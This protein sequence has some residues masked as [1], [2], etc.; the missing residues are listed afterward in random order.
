[1]TFGGCVEDSDALAKAEA[2]VKEL[3]AELLEKDRLLEVVMCDH[4]RDIDD[5]RKSFELGKPTMHSSK[6]RMENSTLRASFDQARQS[7]DLS[8]TVG[9]CKDCAALRKQLRSYQKQW[10]DIS[11]NF[12]QV[13]GLLESMIS[14]TD[15]LV[16]NI[17]KPN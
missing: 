1:M 5:L 17:T 15:N 7:V 2:R 16:N 9:G 11:R 14:R 4:D 12:K 10:M 8:Q 6:K 3:E 13:P